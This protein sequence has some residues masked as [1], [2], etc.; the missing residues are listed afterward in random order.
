MTALLASVS[1]TLEAVAAMEAGVDVID[2]KNPATG[3]LGAVTDTVA[4]DVVA[5]EFQFGVSTRLAILSSHDD[6]ARLPRLDSYYCRAPGT[7]EAWGTA[8]FRVRMG[9]L[10]G[11]RSVRRSLARSATT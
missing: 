9:L 10:A 3:A 4:R 11:A 6:P 5:R 1:S 2:L 7:L 8:R